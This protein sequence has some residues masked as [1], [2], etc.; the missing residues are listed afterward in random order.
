MLAF[1]IASVKEVI[2]YYPSGTYPSPSEMRDMV[3]DRTCGDQLQL[4]LDKANGSIAGYH[5]QY[6]ESKRRL[7]EL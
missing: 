1:T 2:I 6:S 5:P 7:L 3:F 4:A